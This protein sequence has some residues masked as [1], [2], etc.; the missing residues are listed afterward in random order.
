MK[1]RQTFV[2][3]FL[4]VILTLALYWPAT[5]Y[6][7]VVEDDDLYVFENPWVM[8][9][10]CLPS[11]KWAF[12]TLHAA[13]WHPVTWISHMLDCSMYGMFPGGHHLT[14][15]LFHG[16]DALLLFLLLQG[17]TRRVWPSFIVAALFAWHPLHVES[18]AWVSERKDVLS[19][20]FFLLTLMAYKKYSQAIGNQPT[21]HA[22]PT[23]HP[24]SQPPAQSAHSTGRWFYFLSLIL[25]AVG[26]MSKPMLVTLPFVLLLLDFWPLKRFRLSDF[27]FQFPALRRLLIEKLPFLALS[28]VAS[29]MT[30]VAQHGGGAIKSAEEV[31][32]G[33]RTLNGFAAY[34]RYLG[35]TVYPTG[36]CALY[37]L[38]PIPPIVLGILSALALGC[39]TWLLFRLRSKYPWALVG[40][41]WF[42]GTLVPVIGFVQVG[43]Q[44]MADRYTY[45]P[46]VGLFLTAVLVVDYGLSRWRVAPG[47]ATALASA[48][49][50]L[51]LCLTQ[52]QLAY[53]HDSVTLFTRA[54]SVTSDN[55]MAE[56]NLG[57]ALARNG[58]KPEAVR[59]YRK[60]VRIKP[61]Y[62]Q[63]HYNLGIQLAASGQFDEAAFHFSQALRQNPENE[64][65][66]NNLGVVLAR[67]NK[68][69]LAIGEFR[70]AILLNARYPKPYLNYGKVLQSLGQAGAAATNYSKALDF[71][72]EWPEALDKLAWLLA[73]CPE[74]EWRR[75][76]GAI[77][78]AKRAAELTQNAVPAYLD[79]LACAYAAAGQFSNAVAV[80]GQA[81]ELALKNNEVAL[82]QQLDHALEGYG[83]GHCPPVDWRTTH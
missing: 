1:Q 29:V 23:T 27:R 76:E 36:L 14:N 42:V 73:T 71:D 48:P 75:P 46:L 77:K 58:D 31:P 33:L 2:L 18:V 53:W 65:L 70:R 9:G 67:Q 79:T 43:L 15:V 12:T 47:L 45:I 81:R 72:P 16:V 11:L 4:L 82:V 26:L 63:A 34:A 83:A 52:H 38:S 61:N 8:N 21:D 39:I 60:A 35:H 66:H 80:A 3:G 59:H 50:L 22:P 7:F 74:P 5:H 28:L 56:N 32:L 68:L 13:N 37:P 19:T 54:V 62:A 40:W 78:L 41:L 64:I 57:V 6:E 55:A 69:D 25:F 17:L 10:L 49:L 30:I 44:S 51:C 24:C 20:F